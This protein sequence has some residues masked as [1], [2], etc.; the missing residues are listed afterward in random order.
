[1][2]RSRCLNI[3]GLESRRLLAGVPE[4]QLFLYLLN[5]AR[6][7]PAAYQ[8]ATGVPVD[9]T[10]VAQRQPLAFNP[11]LQA[12]SQFHS[13]EMARHNYF[14]HQSAVTGQ[15]PNANARAH[16]YKLPSWWDSDN[17]YIESIAA[18]TFTNTPQ[19]AL[20]QLIQSPP[21]RDHLLGISEFNAANSEGGIG[22]ATNAN[23]RYT[24]YWTVQLARTEPAKTFV[25]GVVFDDLNDNG[26]YDANEGIGGTSVTVGSWNTVTNE[27]GG[28]AIAVQPQATYQTVVATQQGLLTT[29]VVV[30][31]ENREVDFR[32][33]SRTVAI[34]F[35]SWIASSDAVPPTAAMTATSL[36][37]RH[38]QS[39]PLQ[40]LYRDNVAVDPATLR[41]GNIRVT[42][43]HGYAQEAV[44]V[45]SQPQGT[46]WLVRYDV[47][48][49]GE[50]WTTADNGTYVVQLV[51][52][53]VADSSGN[54]A[55]AQVLGDFQV[56]VSTVVI[57]EDAN[58]DGIVSPI[59]VLA[60]INHLNVAAANHRVPEYS[61]LLD[62]NRDQFISPIDVLLVINYLNV[63]GN[64]EG[65]SRQ[66]STGMTVSVSRAAPVDTLTTHSEEKKRMMFGILRR[67]VEQATEVIQS[68]MAAA[69]QQAGMMS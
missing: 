43:P 11:Q 67:P 35:G 32:I 2:S 19:A 64:G 56:A 20:K 6:H 36:E 61:Q 38:Q 66:T 58:D 69:P 49:T 57:A 27:A 59:D 41:T 31:S 40:I 46:G 53:Q 17:N 62:V 39:H 65:E 29:S 47:L 26:R 52:G 42:G 1:M 51:A 44:Y 54:R 48:P 18:G 12:S 55:L 22:T 45:S 60:V 25:T 9:L 30:G 21:H 16:G 15:W 4:G 63:R 34:D 28:W 5:E 37:L 13:E 8:R 50:T 23:S 14:A 10:S 24:N 33:D 3:E 68:K 7:D